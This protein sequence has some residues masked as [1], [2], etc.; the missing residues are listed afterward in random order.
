MDGTPMLRVS[1]VKDLGV[2]LNAELSFRDHIIQ[3][4][5]KAYRNLGFLL[6]TVGGFTNIRAIT[7]LY[8]ALVRSQLES[9]AVVWAPHEAKYSLMLERV[10][11]KFVRFLYMRLYGVYPFYPLMYPTLFVLGMVGYNEIRSRRE[12]ALV[13]YIFKIIRG[14]L[15]NAD[16]L[17]QVSLR[18]PDRYVWRRRRPPLLALPQGRTNLLNK[19]PLARALGTLNVVAE[20]IDLFCCT[21]SELTRVAMQGKV[22]LAEG[23]FAFKQATAGFAR[24][25]APA[26]RACPPSL[27]NTIFTTT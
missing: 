2:R 24:R 3:C 14:K 18:V 27:V 11:N 13:L 20:R 9:N 4:C 19:A 7:A 1:E 23:S 6:R 25:A 5:K 17:G 10:Q 12:L 22:R 16:V 8:N 26:H 15:F 21:R